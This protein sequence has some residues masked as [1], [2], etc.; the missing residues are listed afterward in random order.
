MRT[1][2]HVALLALAACVAGC[3]P[4]VQEAQLEFRATVSAEGVRKGAVE[5][6]L[7]TTGTVR[8]V[9]EAKVIVES[10]GKIQVARAPGAGRR[11]Q[12]GDEVRRGQALAAVASEELRTSSRVAARKKSL[13]TAQADYDRNLR[14]YEEGLIS[15]IQV[16]EFETKLE[17]ARADYQNALLQESKGRLESPLSGVLTQ[18][19]NMADGSY[20]STGTVVAEV[21]DFDEVFVDLDLGSGEVMDVRPGQRVRVQSYSS[22]HV[23]EGEVLR[24]APAIDPKSRTFRV[25]VSATNPER[26]L[27]PGMFVRADIVVED[28]KE[29]T[30]VPT[31]AVVSREGSWYVFVVEAQRAH[32]REVELGLVSD[33]TAEVVDG[34]AVGEQVVVTGQDTLQDGARVIVRS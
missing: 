1:R 5:R 24:I 34:L 33:L 7:T 26:R 31:D 4:D 15:D 2:G 21:M 23:F 29:A 9:R 3:A 16:A 11:L 17:N 12:V 28:R 8:P 14:L 13:E 6:I 27:R 20:A 10:A 22:P 19:T 25:E 30:V 32:L 18:V